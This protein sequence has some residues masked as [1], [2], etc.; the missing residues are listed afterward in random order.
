MGVD[1]GVTSGAR[2][3][4]V[5]TVG[6]VKMGLGVP[7]LLGQ[8]EID[9]VDLVA[10][11][12]NAHE[13]VVGLDV[14][15]NEALGVDVLDAANELVGEQED[16]LEGEFAVAEVEEVLE[17]RAEQV[18]DHGIVV[19][20]GAEPSDEGNAHAAGEGLVDASLILELRVLGLDGLKLDG[21][22]LTGDD[23]GACAE[24]QS[25]RCCECSLV[26]SYQ[27]RCRRNCRY[28]SCGQ[29]GTCC[30]RGG[31]ACC[32]WA[33]VGCVCLCVTLRCT[34]GAVACGRE[35]VH[36]PWSSCLE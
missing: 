30:P 4:L 19:A 26:W 1:G 20:L 28:R 11:L 14:A 5:L 18:E 25:G 13:E 21:D 36:A 16:G 23:V 34:A 27:G 33:I 15:V 2:Q 3:V 10:S 29:C 32:Q 22:L 6:N 17:G 35:G 12:A 31:P 24:G 7:V 9:H 8:T